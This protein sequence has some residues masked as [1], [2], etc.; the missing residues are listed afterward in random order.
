MGDRK[1]VHSGKTE[2]KTPGQIKIEYDAELKPPGCC[3]RIGL[4]LS[5]CSSMDMERSYL[6]LRENSFESNT[7]TLCCCGFCYDFD[8]INVTY[9]DRAPYK[10]TC[11]PS[12]FPCCCLC[13]SAQPKLDIINKGC[14][15][16]C[17]PI[18]CG[19]T[20]VVMPFEKYPFPCCCCNN[21]VNCLNNCGGFCGPMTG[22]PII[23]SNFYPEPNDAEAFVNVS[24][25]VMFPDNALIPLMMEV[26]LELSDV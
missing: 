1:K 12:P 6:Y 7:T 2:L 11:K 21:R 22:N 20:A 16:C 19:K 14:I 18:K 4:F 25:A 24:R 10:K 23:Y 13:N 26:G 15:I 3:I 17:I 9:F 5:C 8:Y